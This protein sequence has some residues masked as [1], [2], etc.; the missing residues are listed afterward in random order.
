MK[1]NRTIKLSKLLVYLVLNHLLVLVLNMKLLLL[2]SHRSLDELA[3]LRVQLLPQLIPLL[4][5]PEIS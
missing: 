5:L 3:I 2:R 4:L 1:V